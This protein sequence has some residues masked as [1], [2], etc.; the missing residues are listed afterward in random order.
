VF[1]NPPGSGF[2]FAGTTLGAEWIEELGGRARAIL[3]AAPPTAPVVGHFAWR[4]ENV[5]LTAGTVVG[6]FDWSQVGS[7]SEA[8]VIGSAAHQFTIDGRSPRPHVPT[9]DEIRT[10]V[11]DYE[12]ARGTPLTAQQR[13]AARAA[14]V[15]CTAYGARCEHVLGATG[16]PA[17]GG[18]RDR[19]ST[20]G[21]ALLA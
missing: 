7:A 9:A 12:S 1:P 2:D 18:F 19:L 15:F 21:A 8:F 16:A 20:T 10:F 14:Y 5:A 13:V 3:D 11:G 6:V 17:P 4:L